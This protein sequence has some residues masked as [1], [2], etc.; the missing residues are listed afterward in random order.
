[1]NL[2]PQADFEALQARRR[3]QAT[4]EF[5]RRYGR[6][7]GI[8]GTISQGVRT[9]GLRQARY[10]GLDK[11]HLQH[12]LIALAINVQRIDALL[13]HTPL[14]PTR[15]SQFAHLAHRWRRIREQEV[16]S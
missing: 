5:Q 8:E 2:Q 9:L 7:A 1:M 4:P 16:A 11:T 12:V 15:R 13:T 6:R 3:E 10:R 14:G